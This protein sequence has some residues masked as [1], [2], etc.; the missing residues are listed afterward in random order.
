MTPPCRTENPYFRPGRH[1][2]GFER[3]LREEA[4]PQDWTAVIAEVRRLSQQGADPGRFDPL[5][6]AEI[7]QNNG[8]TCLSVLLEEKFSGSSAL[9]R[10]DS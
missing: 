1:S 7:Y 6:I 2:R 10:P 5:E 3:H 9:S 8:A 4:W